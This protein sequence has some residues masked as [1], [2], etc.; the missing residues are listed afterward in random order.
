MTIRRYV[1][2]DGDLIRS[3][4][5]TSKARAELQ[6][7]LKKTFTRIG[8]V[9][10]K[11]VSVSFQF[12]GGDEFQG[13]LQTARPV[14]D[15]INLIRDAIHPMTVRFGIGIGEIVTPIDARP[16]SMDGPAFHKARDALSWSTDF[17]YQSCVISENLE[18]DAE[19]N[20]WLECLSHIRS[21]WSTR[22]MEVTKLY[23]KYEKLEPVAK[24]LGISVQAVSKHL[25]V[26]GYKAFARGKN[27][28][29]KTLAAYDQLV[30]VDKTK[31]TN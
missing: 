29:A 26:S 30:Q 19:A 18:L 23:A 5:L 11:T 7:Q 8:H 13:V 22:A 2:V 21:R 20:A 25:N 12:T 17:L 3:R 10:G 6:T 9:Y 27:V 24:R 31:S 4:R 15:L 16:Q 1:V 14:F 28:L